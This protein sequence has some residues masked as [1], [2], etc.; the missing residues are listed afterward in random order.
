MRQILRLALPVIVAELGWMAMGVVDTIMVGPL[1]PT[2]IGA[3][4]VGNAVFEVTGLFGI[5]LLL[6]LDTLVSQAYGAKRRQDCDRWLWHG[7]YLALVA[8]VFLMG[9]VVAVGPKLRAIGIQPGVFEVAMP[10]VYA[11]NWSVLPLLIYAAFRRYLQSIHRPGIVT[12]ALVS[13]NIVNAVG[14]AWL[15]PRFGVEGSGWST[16]G[17]RI[18]MALVL[19]VY[20][21][22][23]DRALLRNVP[24]PSWQA[25]RTLLLLGGPVALQWLLEIGVFATTTMLAARL[26]PD[27]LAA[28]HIVL[29]IVATTFMVPLGLSSAGA[30]AVGNSVGAADMRMAKKT[31]WMTIGLAVVFMTGAAALL[32]TF[33]QA[34]AGIFTKNVDVMT[35]AVPLLFVSAWFQIF[36]GI[37]VTAS[38]VLRGAGDTRTSM[39]ANLVAHWGLG[40]PT[41]YLLCFVLGWGVI[42]LWAGLSTGLTLVALVLLWWWR[43]YSPRA[44]PTHS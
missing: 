16:L 7:F 39:V 41:G 30:V 28:H 1:G 19:V 6:G 5:G 44:V 32:F 13:A 36:D 3:V 40:L 26:A 25:T 20:A 21:I 22:A 23:T 35:V 37:Q 10:Y 4:G 34:L 14:N 2:A 31:G 27:S 12:F 33:P 15:I 38:G 42:G 29:Q 17:A 11:L 8:A 9:L 18:Y 24:L 43:R